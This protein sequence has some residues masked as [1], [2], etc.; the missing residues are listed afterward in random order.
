MASSFGV[1]LKKADGSAGL[2]PGKGGSRTPGGARR[3][4]FRTQPVSDL[5]AM[6][7]KQDESAS[8]KKTVSTTVTST[9]K[10]AATKTGLSNLKSNT[11]TTLTVTTSKT[12]QLKDGDIQAFDA[13]KSELNKT[14]IEKLLEDEKPNVAVAKT[15]SGG[16]SYQ[17]TVGSKKVHSANDD[18]SSGV[19]SKSSAA[20]V[21]SFG[22][23]KLRTRPGS[24]K[25]D[26]EKLPRSNSVEEEAEKGA[27]SPRSPALR[28]DSP[29]SRE[30]KDNKYIPGV[31]KGW[32][33]NNNETKEK[34]KAGKFNDS[35]IGKVRGEVKQE[36]IVKG[37]RSV[38]PVNFAV[39]SSD[40]SSSSS[41]LSPRGYRSNVKKTEEK[42]TDV[43]ENIKK[44]ESSKS[45]SNLLKL[46]KNEN[47]T[48]VTKNKTE[49]S[50]TKMLI[51]KTNSSSKLSAVEQL[52]RDKEKVKVR[53]NRNSG[54]FSSDSDKGRRS[55]KVKGDMKWLEKGRISLEEFKEQT[56]VKG[57]GHRPLSRASS[58]GSNSSY[59]QSEGKA[60]Q[61]KIERFASPEPPKN[62]QKS[63]LGVSEL[64]RKEFAVS[65]RISTD[66]F[67]DIKKGFETQ[68]VSSRAMSPSAERKP[69]IDLK[70]KVLERKQSFE[71]GVMF[72]PKSSE[73]KEIISPRDRG[74]VLKT[75][76]A[77]KELDAK[78]KKQPTIVRRTKS[79]PIES[80]ADD[81][82]SI[83]YE[84]IGEGPYY[85]DI[86]GIKLA[87]DISNEG[88][89][90]SEAD[91]YEEIPA[92]MSIDDLE[93]KKEY[94]ARRFTAFKKK[95]KGSEEQ[96][97][98]EEIQ[99]GTEGDI[100]SDS[101]SSGI[102]EHVDHDENE[103]QPVS[104]SDSL[105]Q[106][107]PPE[108]PPARTQNNKKKKNKEEKTTKG[109]KGKF[110]KLYTKSGTVGKSSGQAVATTNQSA[111]IMS[112][113]GDKFK[114]LKKT[115]SSSGTNLEALNK[116]EN[117]VCESEGTDTDVDPE[118]LQ[119]GQ[120]TPPPLPPRQS[121]LY[122]ASSGSEMTKLNNTVEVPSRPSANQTEYINNKLSSSSLESK[123]DPPL[124]PRNR[125]SN[126][127]DLNVVV[128]VTPGGGIGKSNWPPGKDSYLH[129]Q[130]MNNASKS[131]DMP[132]IDQT[133][134]P[135]S[136]PSPGDAPPLPQ[137]P[138]SAG[139]KPPYAPS[140][141]T[142]S[143]VDVGEY[144][145]PAP[146]RPPK[147]PRASP[148]ALGMLNQ[149][150]LPVLLRRNAFVCSST[151]RSAQ[152]ASYVDVE[153]EPLPDTNY[154]LADEI[155]PGVAGR[156]EL[157]KRPVSSAYIKP[158][159]LATVPEVQKKKP[160]VDD[161]L[162]LVSKYEED[163]I[164]IDLNVYCCLQSDDQV[165][166]TAGGRYKSQLGSES[167]YQFYNKAKIS[168]ASKR[169]AIYSSFDESDE[170]GYYDEDG[171]KESVYEDLSEYSSGRG[172]LDMDRKPEE[173]SKAKKIS[174]LEMF[175]KKGTVLRTLW[176]E[177]PEVKSSGVLDT[178]TPHEKKLQE[179]MFE[180]ITSEATYLKSLNVLIDVFLMSDELGS[181]LSNKCVITRQER[182]VIFSNIGAIRDTSERFLSA[183]E[184]RWK[185]S[186]LLSDVCDIITEHSSKYFECYVHYCSNQAF[187]DRA[188][189]DL[190]KKPEFAEALK[191]LESHPDCQGLPMISFLL[192]P[193]QRITRLPLLVDAICHRMDPIKDKERHKSAINA[194][195]AQSKVVKKCN[196]GAK[197]MQQTEQMYHI[198]KQIDF[199]ANKE[200]AQIPLI[201]SSRYLVKQGEVTKIAND[202]ASRLP[203]GK[204]RAGK[205]TLHIY[206]FNDMIL[207]T[208]KKG[209]RYIVTDYGQRITLHIELIDNPEK[210]ARVLPLGVPSGCKH[211][212]LLVI[213]ENHEKKQ[214]ETVFACN[215]MSD[216]A[217]W[218]DAVTPV[219]V[220]DDQKIYEEWDC[221]QVQCI[222][223]YTAQEP[224]ELTLDESDVVNVFKKLEDG[225]YEGERLRDGER[226][227]FPKDHTVE[228]VNSHVRARNLRMKYRLM[229]ASQ[230]YGS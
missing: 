222:K 4:D 59:K 189:T 184:S 72:R 179:S 7:D 74:N 94:K 193:M 95:R 225:M 55:P 208:K 82:S 61:S 203:F 199:P 161:V 107:S 153:D 181:D 109:L 230:D 44:F 97:K 65:K 10:T 21:L 17:A 171:D 229:S 192:L 145:Q 200:I 29:G 147:S 106:E 6:F 177:M 51:S 169:K 210:N 114:N 118:Q 89:I 5:K 14:G 170:E 31:A 186:V 11:K 129:G 78:A 81:T 19:V 123:T 1:Q 120:G 41:N 66:K 174:T 96:T 63:G 214:V 37:F 108:L 139:K 9:Q 87:D 28:P 220:T 213:L 88:D 110:R 202:Q 39:N 151:W 165:Y 99:A 154:S 138:V 133:P 187:Q 164:Y 23:T 57:E 13:L 159:D 207:I 209:D 100:D 3:S 158:H 73:N 40:D 20:S 172:S 83:E 206:L 115:K 150:M 27:S 148:Q 105:D 60:I 149:S 155:R 125:I 180:I 116:E 38:S 117:P 45:D 79:L 98:P 135:Q 124:P 35:S 2:S 226:G 43:N 126:N 32:K 36:N 68:T 33:A 212:F 223:P 48:K 224:D 204:A 146:A 70:Q 134:S 166:G 195:N 34:D 8:G 140:L 156:K 22:L 194:F 101:D 16:K 75:V 67:Q 92:N 142:E 90:S 144:M 26:E 176:A 131:P 84:D 30:L 49:V 46:E 211:L 185:E 53:L 183:L 152:E 85:H 137:R 15:Y 80:M 130:K 25:G 121:G 191:R 198:A 12:N 69:K 112:T 47:Q 228:I 197:K 188:V 221:P 227:W 162:K 77:L 91:L 64:K 167:L 218:V 190:K 143:Y 56:K 141:S 157:E 127:L 219:K 128:P 201:S 54:S 182:H 205:Q 42:K 111:G 217:R 102:Y 86:V 216:R 62:T 168:R 196:D 175:G 104:E 24:L 122:R 71:E 76:Q 163:G 173:D 58:S 160:P 52:A 119:S 215:S 50:D 18:S 103:E 132:Y 113:L 93:A 178:I 136:T